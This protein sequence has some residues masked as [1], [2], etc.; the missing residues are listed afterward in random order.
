MDIG[1]GLP[2]TVPGTEAQ[3]LLDWAKRAEGAGFSTLGTIGRLV[4]GGYE[5]LIALTA[6][7]AVTSRIRLTTSVL[8]TPLYTNPALLAKQAASL[9]R[10]SGGRFVLGLGLGGRDDD[11]EAS[12]LSTKGRGRRFEEQLGEL[13]RVWAGEERGFA[14]AIGPRP[15]REG[16]PELIL[17]GGTEA[18]FRRVAEF[19]DGWIM[20]GGTPDMFAEAAAGVDA[21]WQK[22]GRAGSPRKLSLAYFG[23]G[24]DARA[25]ADG[26]LLDY[27]GFLGDFAQQIAG[28]AAVS[29]EMVAQY[30]AAFQAAGCDELIFVP[31]GSGLDQIDLLAEAVA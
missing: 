15:T 1:I 25:Q 21:A 5:E 9:E 30:V 31:T 17:G 24:P 11:Y 19:A 28:S 7:A 3:T 23:L 13:K 20:G 8:L 4:Y 18:S 14:G 22:A 2:N 26:Y 27:Y 16:G 6:A 12:G 10:I 29:A